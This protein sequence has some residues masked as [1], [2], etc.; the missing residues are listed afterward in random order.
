MIQ[1]KALAV[2][3]AAASGIAVAAGNATTPISF[4]AG[5]KSIDHVATAHFDALDLTTLAEED[6]LREARGAPMRFAVARSGGIDV[7]SGGTWEQRGDHSL[8]RYRIQAKDAVSL[9]FGFT[10][11][12]LPPSA[13]L[14]V[15]ASD[16]HADLA[17]PYDAA[18]HN[19]LGQL[20]TPIIA[21]ADVTIELDVASKERDQVEL[22][23]GKVN[24]GYRGFGLHA[25]GYAQPALQVTGEGKSACSPDGIKSGSCNMDVACMDAS[26]P[27]NKPRRAV[28]A[29]TIDGT[30]TCTGSLVNNTANDR[31]LL[32][33]TASHCEVVNNPAG[34]VVYWNYESPTCRT[35]GSAASGSALPKPNMT[36]SGST[37]LARTRNPF[38]DTDCVNGSQCSDTTLIRLNGT[39]DPTWN[40]Y[41]A[42]WDR[43]T[44]AATC[45]PG[46]ANS[47]AGECASIHHPGVEEK[48]ITFVEQNFVLGGISGGTNTHWHAYWDPTP[49]ILPNIPAP[50]PASLPPGVTEPGSSGS[51]LYNASQRL[52]GVLSGGDSACGATG[53][54][55][56]DFYGQLALAWEGEGSSSTRMK[57]WL[58]PGNSGA[59][60]IDG[61]GQSAFNFTLNPAMPAVCNTSNSTSVAL[62]ASYDPGYGGTVS[63]SASGAPPASATSFSPATLTPPT[64]ASTLTLS[65]LSSV[66]PGSYNLTITGTDGV[67]T[68]NQPLTLSVAAPL[69]GNPTLATPADGATDVS[70][71]P[72]LTWNALAGT[73]SYTVEIA[74]DATFTN[75]IAS[76]A[77]I[78]ATSYAASGLSP[79]TTYHWRVSPTN[80]CGDGTASAAASFTTANIICHTV[81]Q[82]IPDSTPAGI[83]D[84]IT[85]SDA[86][87]LSG[88]RVSIK[89]THSY[90]G[91]L[92]FTLHKD[93]TTSA[94]IDR[95][96][97]PASTFGCSGNDIDVTLDDAAASP[98]E[99]TCS[100]TPPA[101]S[102]TLAPNAPGLAPFVGQS[103]AGTWTM[104][105]SDNAGGDTGTFTE[106]CLIPELAPSDVIFKDGFDGAT[107]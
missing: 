47:D 99:S 67:D 54:Q 10:R 45:V 14:F 6:A 64:Q 63:L 36:S 31:S 9:N 89:A 20:W 87:V 17:G 37:F 42:G 27:W 58:D 86:S 51:P 5:F 76:Q 83:N 97:Q 82:A 53:E 101:L 55:L 94:L 91:D 50:Q 46:P 29:Y 74:T 92:K 13:R 24:Q 73:A 81:N 34:I 33:I 23:L 39:A 98:A 60:A 32:F 59:T 90:V 16:R 26:D 79:S 102:G 38:D 77:G 49:P 88:L 11:F 61:I 62:N 72:V 4:G 66:T 7:H 65:G 78:T 93:T 80:A 2:A 1:H 68:V 15:Y 107:P 56:S 103:L 104:N 22:V 100:F 41:W 106:W 71:N 21:A 40:L 95:P 75:I 70:T 43:S 57:D 3:L 105:V 8:W 28:G 85:L 18:S 96:G 12:H 52:V 19:A 35:P 44:T 25:K 69:S 48:R 30:D 84:T